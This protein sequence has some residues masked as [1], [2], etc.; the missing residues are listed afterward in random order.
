MEFKDYVI[1]NNYGEVLENISIKNLTTIGCGGRVKYLYLPNNINSLAV[2]YK[3]INIHEIKYM[4]I[5][6]GSNILHA[7]DYFDGVIISLD[8]IP[9]R[10][11]INDEYMVVTSNVRVGYLLNYM[12][13]LE[14]G[15]LS[16]LAGVPGSVGGAIFMN[17]GAFDDEIGNYVIDVK[18][19]DFY[20]KIITI[21]HD[22]IMFKY[23]SSIFKY[24][25]G[26][27][28]ECKIRYRKNIV[29]KD[30]IK[31]NLELRKLR[32]PIGVKS[33]GSVFKNPKS[34]KAY[35]VIKLIGCDKLQIGDAY[36]SEKHSNFIIN[37]GNAKASDILSIIDTIKRKAL[38]QNII[39]EE[40]IIIFEWFPL[41]FSFKTLDNSLNIY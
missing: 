39:L 7:S 1:S 17:A 31:A 30:K 11:D 9:K 13:N 41:F 35:E 4:I 20:G 34:I 24:I 32:H 10:I 36:I 6:R 5:G 40:E 8:L 25:K 18:Y 27:I 29:T 15:D 12:S 2:V 3:Y 33:M 14:I 19:I 23:R 26:I 37:K 22:D 28:V 21:L 38:E 16:F